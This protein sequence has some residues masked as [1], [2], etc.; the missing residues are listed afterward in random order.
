MLTMDLDVHIQ[1][2]GKGSSAERRGPLHHR[3]VS[4][5]VRPTGHGQM[6]HATGTPGLLGVA[7]PPDRYSAQLANAGSDPSSAIR[8]EVSTGS[9]GA[10]TSN[11]NVQENT[12]MGHVTGTSEKKPRGRPPKL[13]RSSSSTPSRGAQPSG[14]S[15]DKDDTDDD[16]GKKRRGRPPGSKNRTP[17]S[18]G[19]RAQG[20]FT[21]ATRPKSSANTTPA[22]SALRNASTPLGDQAF[23]VIIDPNSRNTSPGRS[24]S[25]PKRKS[26][27]RDPSRRTRGRP[28]AAS[29]AEPSYKVYECRWKDCKAELH[30]LDTLRKHVRKV[31][32]AKAAFGGI[33]CLWT[34][35]GKVSFVQD[36]KTGRHNRVHQNLDFGAEELWDQHMDKKH[37]E[38]FAWDLGDGPSAG[39]SG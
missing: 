6:G 27:S 33:P 28:S 39:P 17:Q 23:A 35:C 12:P 1:N 8:V 29:K 37:L 4:H 9:S 14:P 30:N 3:G 22:R 13:A 16:K 24:D 7:A 15:S 18:S 5:T 20:Q 10:V 2:L 26:E 19:S 34:G 21:V 38:P 36:R 32:R 31:H 25:R 11:T